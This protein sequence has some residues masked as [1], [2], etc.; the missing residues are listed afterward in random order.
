MLFGEDL[1]S[2]VGS[3]ITWQKTS[4]ETR[5]TAV[6]L[7]IRNFIIQKAVWRWLKLQDWTSKDK[8]MT[9]TFCPLPIERRWPV[10]IRSLRSTAVY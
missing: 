8:T 2:P 5:P 4:V 7:S 10:S 1:A 3:Q 9:D 6:P